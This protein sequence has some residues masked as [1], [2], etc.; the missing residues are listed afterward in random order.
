MAVYSRCMILLRG[1]IL[2]DGEPMNESFGISNPHRQLWRNEEGF[3]G[4]IKCP[5]YNFCLFR[6]DILQ[7]EEWRPAYRVN[8]QSTGDIAWLM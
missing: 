6:R 2:P 3:L 1:K 4:D 5:P 7:S 8:G